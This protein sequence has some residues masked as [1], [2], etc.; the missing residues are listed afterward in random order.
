MKEIYVGSWEEFEDELKK[1]FTEHEARKQASNLHV[2][3]F[4]FRGQSNF[5][6]KL[7]TTLERYAPGVL[8]VS[9]YFRR[10]HAAKPQIETF[11]GHHWTIPTPPE[12]EDWLEEQD[13]LGFSNIHAYDYMVYLRHH[14]FPSPL[15][16]WSRSPYVAAF[17]AFRHACE[18][19]AKYVSIYAYLEYAGKAKLISPQLPHTTVRGPYVRSDPRHF[20]QQSQYT[21]CIVFSNGDWVYGSH[22]EALANENEDQDLLW[23]FNVPSIEKLK[24]LQLLDRYNLNSFSL[25]GSE[26]SLMETLAF[27]ELIIKD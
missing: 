22:E 24:V 26:E 23:K 20:F 2:S 12:Y 27:R 14:S 19:R 8:R 13:A 3:N 16:D 5:E 11:T 7:E 21:I 4:L 18:R 1:L 15:L 25:F 17:F 10:I 6:W 9:E